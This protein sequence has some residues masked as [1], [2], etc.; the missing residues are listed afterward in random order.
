MA[1]L[2]SVPRR[3][4]SGREAQT[5]VDVGGKVANRVSFEPERIE[6]ASQSGGHG[7]WTAKEERC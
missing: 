2:K 7:G 3:I 4:T 1:I 6:V 5:L